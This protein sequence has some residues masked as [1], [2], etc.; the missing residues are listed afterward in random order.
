MSIILDKGRFKLI[1]ES[2]NKPK[3]NYSLSKKASKN[4]NPSKQPQT[5]L[6]KAYMG[7]SPNNR[8]KKK[9]FIKSYN[10]STLNHVH[11]Y[12]NSNKK[13]IDQK[14]LKYNRSFE[15]GLLNNELAIENNDIE[16]NKNNN[17]KNKSNNAK[18]KNNKSN[19]NI[20]IGQVF[21]S[22]NK[23][24]TNHKMNNKTNKNIIKRLD[25]KFKSLENNI[26]DK[27][28]ENVI[29]HDEMIIATNK[30]LINLS[31]SN[32]IKNNTNYLSNIININNNIDENL[33]NSSF[34]NNKND[35]K[36]M[37]V[38]NYSDTVPDDMLILEIKLILE[39]ILELQKSYHKEIDNILIHYFNNKKEYKNIINKYDVM[40]KKIILLQK[41]SEKKNREEN[42]NC[43]DIYNK[44]NFQEINNIN[45]NEI[46]IWKLMMNLEENENQL[47]EK[48]I[49]LKEIFKKCVFEK[50][51]KI[52]NMND[53]EKKIIENLMKKYKFIPHKENEINKINNAK[54]NNSLK[55]YNNKKILS[56]ISQNKNIN[57]FTNNKFKH[58]KLLN[59][60]IKTKK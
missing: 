17:E 25:E 9:P 18:R 38:E 51:Y 46:S 41:I 22:G 24:K 8:I 56:P 35:F 21:S 39:K 20:N 36:I 59:F 33:I 1:Y 54:S 53:I 28:Y 45:K 4:K 60:S 2:E 49:Q 40:Q 43:F 11:N 31:K 32:E 23:S 34:E 6:L 52:K 16:A 3:P 50:Y 10:N 58:K 12:K 47:K 19:S 27:K 55:K 30:K 14:Q 7:L 44:S 5:H 48:K 57:Y 13:N 37:Y 26:I 15:G 29:D 42:Q